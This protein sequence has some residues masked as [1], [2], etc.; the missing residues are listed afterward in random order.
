MEIRQYKSRDK[1]AVVELVRQFFEDHQRLSDP[2]AV[3]DK[4]DA[5]EDLEE[6]LS[7]P[8]SIL[9]VL[10]DSGMKAFLRL[11]VES[12]NVFWIEDMGVERRARGQNYGG[13]FLQFA[14]NYVQEKGAKSLFT[15]ISLKNLAS[16]DFFVKHGFDWLNMIELRKNFYE[17]KEQKVINLLGKVFK[18]G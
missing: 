2:E 7:Y 8:N 18:I 6:W 9:F 14:E 11:R 1:E 17:K 4:K 15:S 12:K 5:E 3:Y 16:I 13:K 10:E